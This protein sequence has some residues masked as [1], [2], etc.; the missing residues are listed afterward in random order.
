MKWTYICLMVSRKVV[1]M[2]NNENDKQDWQAVRNVN[3]KQRVLFHIHNI[4]FINKLV[5]G[6]QK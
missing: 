1:K 5:L 3:D 2:S 4:Y 6:L